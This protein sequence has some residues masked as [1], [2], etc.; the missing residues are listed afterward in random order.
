MSLDLW[1][2][3]VK[4]SHL[5]Q[6]SNAMPR[7]DKIYVGLVMA[8]DDP[9][10]MGRLMVYI[11]EL[12]GGRMTDS[13]AWFLVNYAS[14]FA[15]A[16]NPWPDL[17]T[18]DSGNKRDGTTFADTQKS[19]GF[20]ATPP[21][22]NNQVLIAFASGD[23]MRGFWFACLYQQNMNHMVP[24][25]GA[26]KSYDGDE[27]GVAQPVAEYNKDVSAPST[28]AM[29]QRASHPLR[30]ALKK[31]GLSVDGLR[32]VSTAS[33]RRESPSRVFGLLTP[34]G[35]QFVMDD[36][37]P[38]NE[39]N[40]YIRLRTV[41]GAQVVISDTYGHIYLISRDGNS[42]VELN[43]DGHIDVYS[44]LAV[45]I[46]GET[47]VNIR[48]DQDVNIEAGRNINMKAVEGD[49][50]L[51]VDG[52]I[53]MTAARNF[54][55]T[56]HGNG[57]IKIDSHLKIS[58]LNYDLRVDQDRTIWVGKDTHIKHPGGGTRNW[59]EAKSYG[60][61]GPCIIPQPVIISCGD[62]KDAAS[63]GSAAVPAV[64]THALNKTVTASVTTRVPEHEPWAPHT[65]PAQGA[66]KES[67]EPGFDPAKYQDLEQESSP[68]DG[69]GE[70][71]AVDRMATS[72][73]G[74]K[75]ITGLNDNPFSL[76]AVSSDD[77][78]LRIGYGT[79][80]PREEIMTDFRYGITEEDAWTN[81]ERRLNRDGEI[82]VKSNISV[83][84]TQAQYD[85]LVSLV[86][87]LGV[88][89]LS[90]EIDGVRL[91]DVINEGRHDDAAKIIAVLGGNS[92]RRRQESV[93]YATCNYGSL[94]DRCSWFKKGM[95]DAKNVYK[96]QNDNIRR[97]I[98]GSCWRM[99]Q[100]DLPGG[101]EF[102]T[103]LRTKYPKES[104]QN[105]KTP[106][107]SKKIEEHSTSGTIVE[108]GDMPIGKYFKLKDFC[109]SDTARAAGIPNNPTE[110]EVEN[111]KALVTNVIDPF[112]DGTGC[113]I[114]I[115]S[116]YRSPALNNYMRGGRADVAKRSQH[117]RG[118]AVDF[119][120]QG[121]T[122]RQAALWI[123]DN[124]QFDQLIHEARNTRWV[125]VSWNR[126]GNR[127]NDGRTKVFSWNTTSG[128]KY[129]GEI[130]DV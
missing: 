1:S 41:Q 113:Q 37:D 120:P 123:A 85:A 93:L 112:I 119:I 49:L 39:Q 60:F 106:C 19:Y 110:E 62:V 20:W 15:G 31:Q 53:H 66:P 130:V 36:G 59:G 25:I 11:P 26:G 100:T 2:R 127:V 12:C 56:A 69:C 68:N 34:G 70:P 57:D 7:Y 83:E 101:D 30:D 78:T 6:S 47:D 9:D 95:N 44:R 73:R 82:P 42:W 38:H 8:N 80:G 4:K 92:N 86:L 91:R 109:Q 32:G 98:Q 58:S 117:S 74:K 45:N 46:H 90:R 21:D 108:N 75:F 63:A 10:G 104:V 102:V 88:G 29:T 27:N 54:S 103:E 84:L 52:N 116:G 76:Y 50:K 94:G 129:Y 18:G 97:Q 115:T 81:F 111:L 61:P 35:S 107:I 28:A 118:Q 99:N 24:G 64:N 33:A 40:A 77:Q 5:L 43:N 48:A 3:K 51:E 96:G 105:Y 125:H 55:L 72:D 16:T 13:E 128:R 65:V 89:A 14:P 87:D 126:A 17:S 122:T 67:Y 114:R 71:K 121:M 23:P 79:V 124:L 22:L